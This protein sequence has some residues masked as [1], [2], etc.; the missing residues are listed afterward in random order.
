MIE[1]VVESISRKEVVINLSYKSDGVIPTNEF[2]YN[3]DL[4]IGD[5]VEV[6]VLRAWKTAM[7]S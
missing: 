6:Y 1:G 5:T 4:S 2:R 3:P 7:V